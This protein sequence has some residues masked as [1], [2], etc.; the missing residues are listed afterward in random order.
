MTRDEARK[1]I[2]DVLMDK[3]RQD[4]FPNATQLAVI[5]EVLPQDLLPDY[6][7][8]LIEKAEQDSVPST[9]VEA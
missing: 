9:P 1:W 2:A 4:R 3:V 8:F 5:E 6:L 7:E